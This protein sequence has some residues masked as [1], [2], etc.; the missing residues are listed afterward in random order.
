[1]STLFLLVIDLGDLLR[2]DLEAGFGLW[3]RARQAVVPL[4]E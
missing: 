3:Q 4:A 1:L 2:A